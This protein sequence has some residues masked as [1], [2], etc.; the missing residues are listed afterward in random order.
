MGG[1]PDR[2]SVSTSAV[3]AAAAAATTG[4]AAAAAGR[5]SFRQSAL[6][7]RQAR[8][9]TGA[10]KIGLSP[11]R[12]WDICRDPSRCACAAALRCYG[13]SR[14]ARNIPVFSTPEATLR[15]RPRPET[16]PLGSRPPPRI[17][18]AT[19]LCI[20]LANRLCPHR[21]RPAKPRATQHSYSPTTLRPLPPQSAPR[22]PSPARR[23]GPDSTHPETRGTDGV[24]G[25]V[26]SR[27]ETSGSSLLRGAPSVAP[28]FPLFSPTR[29]PSQDSIYLPPRVPGYG[30][31]G[32]GG[33]EAPFSETRLLR[34]SFVSLRRTWGPLRPPLLPPPPR[35]FGLADGRRGG[36]PGPLERGGGRLRRRPFPL[37]PTQAAAER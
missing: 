18:L 24:K 13:R 28:S 35:R 37:L 14:A 6:L 17:R 12:P 16:I 11:S 21:P 25:E 23:P 36:R 22:A 4:A 30:V 3:G 15:L 9:G 7:R 19:R 31:G 27:R 29:F 32:A 33:R 1:R 26:K 2:L 8:G 20:Y 10:A 5:P 34:E